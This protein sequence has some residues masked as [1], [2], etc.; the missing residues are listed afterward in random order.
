MKSQFDDPDAAIE[1]LG[2]ALKVQEQTE[3][4]DAPLGRILFDSIQAD[5]D[6]P[7]ADVS[8]MDGYALRLSDIV[9]GEPI[10]FKGVSV[11]GVE[12]PISD[13]KLV[14]VFTGAIV[15]DGFDTVVKREDTTEATG[16]VT[17]GSET[18]SR[19]QVGENIRRAGEN[20]TMGSEV[21]ASG[22]IVS[23]AVMA[24]LANFGEMFP[25]VFC[26]TRVAVLTTGDEVL[27]PLTKK[28]QPWQLRNSNQACIAA[29]LRAY[30]FI[31]I[32]TVIHREDD[33]ESLRTTLRRVLEFN[34]AVVMTGGVSKGDFDYVPEVVKEIGG[35][36]VFHGLPIRPGKPILGAAT[37]EGKLILGLP[38]NPVSA[39]INCH[40]FLMPLLRRQSGQSRWQARPGLALLDAPPRKKLPL[41][42]MLLVRSSGAGSAALVPSKG[43]GDLVAL[44]QSDG[45]VCVPPGQ[46]STGPWPYYPWLC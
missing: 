38:G 46:Q 24:C 31:D 35:E 10:S 26:K 19:L 43:S 23:A 17:I 5:R 42:A 28:L 44:G 39:T 25:R 13:E 27:D 29:M 7:A 8:A 37:K 20:A 3:L 6:S 30:P 9:A 33:R 2:Q 15:P 34:D 40:R 21:V 41:H 11:P 16:S 12:P 22:E 4:S 14:Q 18:L 1:S 36:I 32:T 45:Y